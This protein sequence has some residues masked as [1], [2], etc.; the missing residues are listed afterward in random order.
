MKFYHG[1][2]TEAFLNNLPPHSRDFS[3]ELGGFY[4]LLLITYGIIRAWMRQ[5]FFKNQKILHMVVDMC[6]LYNFILSG[7]QNTENQFSVMGLI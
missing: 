1:T 2:S 3:R 4:L 5:L 7:V 6:I